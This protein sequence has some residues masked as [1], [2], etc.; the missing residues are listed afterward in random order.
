MHIETMLRGIKSSLFTIVILLCLN[1]T[2]SVGTLI[3][4]T[5]ANKDLTPE[6]DNIEHMI[7]RSHEVLKQE[8]RTTNVDIRNT[9]YDNIINKLDSGYV[10]IP[11]E[12]IKQQ[13]KPKK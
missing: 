13:V 9:L 11:V 7:G 6:F 5:E 4:K 8:I 12:L 3:S 1:L 2:L 10:M